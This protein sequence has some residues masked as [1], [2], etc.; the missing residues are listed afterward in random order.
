LWLFFQVSSLVTGKKRQTIEAIAKAQ[1]LEFPLRFREK[2]FLPLAR[3]LP[4]ISVMPV[5][6][7]ALAI[8]AR[9][10]P[11]PPIMANRVQARLTSVS[12]RKS[13]LHPGVL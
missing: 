12:P 8:T 4:V 11:A 6:A 10:W 9:M 2:P 7:C 1:I 5:D 3:L 13:S